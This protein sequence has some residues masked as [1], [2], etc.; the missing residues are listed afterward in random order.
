MFRGL[1]DVFVNDNDIIVF[2]DEGNLS[3][4]D[5]LDDEIEG[6]ELEENEVTHVFFYR[7]IQALLQAE[8]QDDLA[9]ALIGDDI[10]AVPGNTSDNISVMDFDVQGDGGP[11]AVSDF[12]HII[13][14][15]SN[16]P[17]PLEVVMVCTCQTLDQATLNGKDALHD[18]VGIIFQDIIQDEDTMPV[19]SPYLHLLMKLRIQL[20]IGQY[21]IAVQRHYSVH[22]KPENAE[23]L[24]K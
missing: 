20:L 14:V 15:T 3:E 11:E 4:I 6:N 16:T 13:L 22:Q 10:F 8:V 18:T 1:R 7:F 21:T 12:N 9:E 17:E 5:E 23:H 24:M 2:I 19:V